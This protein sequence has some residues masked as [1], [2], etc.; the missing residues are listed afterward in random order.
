[1]VHAAESH[2]ASNESSMPIVRGTLKTIDGPA[3]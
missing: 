3:P 1:L 2:G